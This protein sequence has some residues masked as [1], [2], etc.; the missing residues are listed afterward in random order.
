MTALLSRKAI[1][2]GNGMVVLNERWNAEH[3]ACPPWAKLSG[4]LSE[5]GV[6]QRVVTEEEFEEI[7]NAE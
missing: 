4:G 5:A 6:T 1:H 3:Y 2:L 7:S